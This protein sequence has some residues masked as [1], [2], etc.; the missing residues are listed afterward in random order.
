[1]KQMKRKINRIIASISLVF[2]FSCSNDVGK[3]GQV[4]FGCDCASKI[5]PKNIQLILY[6]FKKYNLNY[7]ILTKSKI[8]GKVTENSK[9]FIG[10]KISDKYYTRTYS[11]LLLNRDNLIIDVKDYLKINITYATKCEVIF[12]SPE[13]IDN[14]I[15]FR[16][17]YKLKHFD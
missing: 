9:K 5:W 14:K 17:N 7:E 1:M 13:V 11:S 16:V 8:E 12:I 2:I 4:E 15:N 6:N 10:E 3:I